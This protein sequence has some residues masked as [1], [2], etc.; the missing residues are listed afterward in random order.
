[1]PR[2]HHTRC[3]RCR[4]TAKC[5]LLEVLWRLDGQGP[6]TWLS[7]WLCPPCRLWGTD[8]VAELGSQLV[9]WDG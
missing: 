5:R 9:L 7:S 3:E 8:L 1:M 2:R 6:W 4:V